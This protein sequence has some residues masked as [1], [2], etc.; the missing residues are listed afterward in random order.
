[1]CSGNA[2]ASGLVQVSYGSRWTH[3][4]RLR[5]K[6]PSFLHL[7]HLVISIRFVFLS[8]CTSFDPIA[9]CAPQ[10]SQ[11]RGHRVWS[12]WPACALRSAS[13]VCR[14]P[15]LCSNATQLERMHQ[16]F[17]L[18]TCLLCRNF[19]VCDPFPAS[20]IKFRLG[21]LLGRSFI[22]LCSSYLDDPVPVYIR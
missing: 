22:L 13:R 2:S 5:S 20:E 21:R 1:M 18:T 16:Y 19:G 6:P 11:A 8:E 10:R 12:A 15:G 14:M 7:H 9:S 3:M 17:C 4:T